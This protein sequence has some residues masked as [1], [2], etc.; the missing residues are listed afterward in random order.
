MHRSYFRSELERARGEKGREHALWR[1]RGCGIQAP[2][3]MSAELAFKDCSPLP[4]NGRAK[5]NVEDRGIATDS[6]RARARRSLVPSLA[7]G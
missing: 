3:Q 2:A 1:S 6:D 5:E 7:P 4:S